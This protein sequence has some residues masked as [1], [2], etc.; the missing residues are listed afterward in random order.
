VTKT[1]ERKNAKGTAAE[2]A[3]WL[4]LAASM[5]DVLYIT[6]DK[7]VVIEVEVAPEAKSAKIEQAERS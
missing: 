4:P 6:D 3:R 5:F 7:I 1:S 2:Q